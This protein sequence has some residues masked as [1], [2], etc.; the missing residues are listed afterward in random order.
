LL[1][2]VAALDVDFPEICT[3][4]SVVCRLLK[5]DDGMSAETFGESF[6]RMPWRASMWRYEYA[7]EGMQ[8][9][10]TPIIISLPVAMLLGMS[11]H[12]TSPSGW[13]RVR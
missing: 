3:T 8:A 5:I 2:S 10:M 4:G 1:P 12:V 13:M 6:W 9:H 11:S 7:T